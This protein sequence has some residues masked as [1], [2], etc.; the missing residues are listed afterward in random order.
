MRA[1]RFGAGQ[2]PPTQDPSRRAAKRPD[3]PGP[4]PTSKRSAPSASCYPFA[5]PGS[6]SATRPLRKDAERNRDRIVAAARAA[7][8]ERGI[9]V[10]VEEIARRAEVGM[11]TLYRRFPTKGDLVDA[12]LE[13]AVAE[14]CQAAESALELDDPWVGFTTFLERVFELHVRNRGLKDVIASARHDRRRLDALRAQMRPLVSEIVGRAQAQGTLRADFAAEDVP[15]LFWTGG[16]V[17]EVTAD[18]APDHWRRYLGFVLD[19]LRAGAATPLPRPPL[20]RAQLDRV[21][22]RKSG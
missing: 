3:L 21:Q 18:V 16:R 4:V 20:T 15:M 22:T 13:D 7:F 14:V 9:D 12:V 2:I 19:G 11:G 10:S 6:A 5:M 8:A 1:R 17:A